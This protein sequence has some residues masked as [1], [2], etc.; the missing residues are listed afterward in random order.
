MRSIL[1]KDTTKEE[2]EEIVKSS[3]DRTGKMRKR[4]MTIT[5]KVSGHLQKYQKI[6]KGEVGIEFRTGSF[7]WEERNDNKNLGYHCSWYEGET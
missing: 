4:H 7:R 6:I 1:I 5:S 3:L 2:R